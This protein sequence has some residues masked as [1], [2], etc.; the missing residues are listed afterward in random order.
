[1][2]SFY[3]GRRGASFVMSKSYSSIAEMI[4]DF[5]LDTCEVNYGEYVLINNAG[6]VDNGKIYRR[7]YIKNDTNGAVYVGQITGP[8]GTTPTLNFGSFD[9]VANMTPEGEIYDQG[10]DE[11]TIENGGLVPGKNGDTFN[12]SIQWSFCSYKTADGLEAHS[13]IG[14][15]IPYP[16]IEI[17][18][19]L[20]DPSEIINEGNLISEDPSTTGHPFYKKWVLKLP[21]GGSGG[22]GSSSGGGSYF[23]NLRVIYASADVESYPGQQDDIDNNRQI[24]VYDYYENGALVPKTYWVGDYNVL[25]DIVLSEDGTLTLNYTHEGSVELEQKIKWATKT[26]FEKGK[27][28]IYYNDGTEESQDILLIE[29]V[30]VDTGENEGE[31]SQKIVISYNDETTKEIGQPLNYIMRTVVTPD[32]HLL[33]LYSD[34]A[35]R[36]QEIDNGTNYSYDGRDDWADMGSIKDENGILIGKNLFVEDNPTELSSMTT[37]INYLNTTYPNGLTEEGMAGKV[38]TVGTQTGTKNIYA[39]DY[40]L[41]Q[42]SYVGWFYVGNFSSSSYVVGAEDSVIAREAAEQLPVGGLWFILEDEEA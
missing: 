30:S 24:L 11:Y 17:E 12:D 33:F 34:P 15:K 22:G 26:V 40:S 16:V 7:E 41:K 27:F 10:S 42:G 18:A 21:N 8:S 3:G 36:Q 35:R 32:Y 23:K 9:E 2:S 14:F 37:T 5:G 39:F 19:N 25:E 20:V 4:I 31:G 29:D 28:T 6:S 13:Y 1:M 38:V